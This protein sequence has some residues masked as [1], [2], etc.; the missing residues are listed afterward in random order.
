MTSPDERA[1]ALL[2]VGFGVEDLLAL[3]RQLGD[4]EV[5]ELWLA[6]K[7]LHE[8]R[9]R[10]CRS[11]THLSCG[12]PRRS[13]RALCDPKSKKTARRTTTDPREV[14]CSECKAINARRAVSPDP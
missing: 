3:A 10:A 12:E 9:R 6:V 5:E 13:W 1:R 2:R 11:A 4:D 8:S 7:A 14:T